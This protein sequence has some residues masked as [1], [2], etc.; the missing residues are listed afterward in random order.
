[1]SNHRISL[2]IILTI[3]FSSLQINAA[4]HNIIPLT[5]QSESLPDDFRQALFITPVSA[6]VLLN[7]KV[8][9]DALIML[10]END[11]VKLISFTDS[12]D[13]SLGEELREYWLN[14]LQKPLSIGQCSGECPSDLLALEY[15]L[16]NAQLSLVTKDAGQAAVPQWHALP[17][18]GSAGLI[19]SNQLNLSANQGQPTVFNWTGD[20]EGSVGNWT[21]VSRMLADTNSYH[22]R[23]LNYSA[24]TL[25]LEHE[26]EGNFVRGG[27]FAPD[28]QGILRTPYTRG[29]RVSTL[30]GAMAGTSDAR[31]KNS[32]SVSLYPIYVTANREGVVE[33]YRNGSLLDT[34]L[35]E[36]GLQP[37]D[38]TRLPSGIYDVEIRVLEDGQEVSR[39]NETIHKPTQWKDSSRRLRYNLFAGQLATLSGSDKNKQDG[40]FA[41]GTSLNYLLHSTLVGGLALQKNA[42]EYQTGMSLDWQVYDKVKLYGNAYYSNTTGP[43]FDSQALWF[44]GSGSISLNHS[45]SWYRP[46]YI[47]G[48]VRQRGRMD[49]RTSLT[50]TQR[51]AGNHSIT[52]RI[53]HE[54]SSG[55]MGYDLSWATRTQFEHTIV[56]WQLSGFDRPY[57]DYNDSRNHGISLT[58]SFSLGKQEQRASASIGT[59]N[60]SKGN[61]D[62][63]A[64]ASISQ[65]WQKGPIKESSFGTTVDR[66]GIGLNTWNTLDSSWVNG[67]AWGMSSTENQKFSGGVNLS[68]TLAIGTDGAVM[69][70]HSNMKGAG[71]IVDVI[72]DDPS[73]TLQANHDNGNHRMTTGRNYIPVN[74]WKA[75]V[76]EVDFPGTEDPGL[77]VWPERVSYHLNRGGVSHHTVRVMKTVMVMGRITDKKGIPVPGAMVVNHA[78]KGVTE[79][80]GIFTMS[81]SVQ[82]PEITIETTTG[83]SCKVRFP[84]EK[85]RDDGKMIY[86]GNLLCG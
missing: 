28:S 79:H 18:T 20:L 44:Y 86:A 83:L 67:S 74:A 66:H 71:V 26:M 41:A 34:Q 12:F 11:T 4:Q 23:R 48:Y 36:P 15:S 75:G 55:G 49:E 5:I 81:L 22:G 85:I 73:V 45:R 59:R 35:I 42:H 21:A 19:F 10:Y 39:A 68:N 84:A 24:T 50:M 80:D 14:A 54:S 56:N 6:R 29:G 2:N 33:I 3:G 78:S 25:F 27:Y 60:D 65:T 72:S 9:G 17:E 77:K 47:H 40:K 52:A 61:R 13:S 62:Q 82:D 30:V 37:I 38:T 69:S 8:L 70:Q 7:G 46:E 57:R 31:L 53:S 58:A 43:G 32:Q 76:I 1:M 64:S 63:Y 51:I 16:T